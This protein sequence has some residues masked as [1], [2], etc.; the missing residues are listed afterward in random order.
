YRPQSRSED[1]RAEAMAE[2][3]KLPTDSVGELFQGGPF[4]S[5]EYDADRNS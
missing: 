1:F 2:Q 3:A 5:D 4:C